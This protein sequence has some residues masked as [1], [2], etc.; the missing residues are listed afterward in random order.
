MLELKSGIV[1]RIYFCVSFRHLG[2]RIAVF[3]NPVKYLAAAYFG[4]ACKETQIGVLRQKSA[5]NYVFAIL[6]RNFID[7]GKGYGR[8]RRDGIALSVKEHRKHRKF[9]ENLF[10]SRIPLE[11]T[12]IGISI[13]NVIG[14]GKSFPLNPVQ[15]SFHKQFVIILSRKEFA[16]SSIKIHHC[17]GLESLRNES[18][19]FDES[20]LYLLEVR[21]DF[22]KCIK[23]S[24]V[25]YTVGEIFPETGTVYAT[26]DIDLFEKVVNLFKSYSLSE[27]G[28]LVNVFVE[29]CE[30]LKFCAIRKLAGSDC[31]VEDSREC[32]RNVYAY[33]IHAVFVANA[34]IIG[35]DLSN[36]SKSCVIVCICKFESE[37]Y[38]NIKITFGLR[39]YFHINRKKIAELL[40]RI[41][42]NFTRKRKSLN[43]SLDRIGSYRAV[44][45]NQVVYRN[46]LYRI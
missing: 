20:R 3:V 43:K 25:G 40:V 22:L 18:Y 10:Q 6:I 32:L 39:N 42:S 41:G 23:Y 9:V 14:Y 21:F 34:Y 15:P 31:L 5:F 26:Y 11:N 29:S 8:F 12:R 7:V 37:V 13:L 28:K 30:Y 16:V 17:F 35:N 4:Y 1:H 44:E 45:Y 2:Y 33:R 24:F 19:E 36:T 38:G 27:F 46:R